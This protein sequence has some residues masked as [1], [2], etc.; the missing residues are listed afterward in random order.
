MSKNLFLFFCC[1]VYNVICWQETTAE[2]VYFS[3]TLLILPN[4]YNSFSVK[5]SFSSVCQLFFFCLSTILFNF[6]FFFLFIKYF[7]VLFFC[8]LSIQ[9]LFSSPRLF[10]VKFNSSN[11]FSISFEYLYQNVFLFILNHFKFEIFT[12]I[13]YF[14]CFSSLKFTNFSLITI[15]FDLFVH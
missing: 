13:S 2:K 1:L 11:I 8:C 7:T 5:I 3:S 12:G 9:P 15:S 4:L 10:S 6:I 14:Y